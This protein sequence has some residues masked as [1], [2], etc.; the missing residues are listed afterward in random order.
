[1]PD[2]DLP[3][4]PREVTDRVRAPGFDAVLARAGRQRRRW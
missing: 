3:D 4:L 2:L 1:M